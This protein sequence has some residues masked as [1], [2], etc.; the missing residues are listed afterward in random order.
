M[1]RHSKVPRPR[2]G[3]RLYRYRSRLG[4]TQAQVA[5]A[6]GERQ[7]NISFWERSDKPPSSDVLP[8]L[9][10]VLGVTIGQILGLRSPK[11][12][13]S[14]PSSPRLERRLR[15]AFEEVQGLPRNRQ[16]LVLDLIESVVEHQKRC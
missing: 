14:L 9:A 3:A 11:R 16:K 1:A 5:A 4:L 6:I 15:A 2:Q 12:A 7:E 10:A 8:A 13:N